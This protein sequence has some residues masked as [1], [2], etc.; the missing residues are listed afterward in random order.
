MRTHTAWMV[1]AASLL[2]SNAHADH[3]EDIPTAMVVGTSAGTASQDAY[4]PLAILFAPLGSNR[5]FSL[6]VM[7]LHA[8]VRLPD[9][10][11]EPG[12][13]LEAGRGAGVESFAALGDVRVHLFP[14][15]RV[16]PTVMLGG[17]EIVEHGTSTMDVQ[18]GRRGAFMMGPGLQVRIDS[19]WTATAELRLM[20]V[21]S[22]DFDENN[23][24]TVAYYAAMGSITEVSAKAGVTYTF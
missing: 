24:G 11:L 21:S 10:W 8:G 22:E 13:E 9:G 15:W 12:V 14:R 2:A 20:L 4:D 16:H 17:G 19:H 18:T 23:S 3:H 1:A 7:Q 6:A 5:T